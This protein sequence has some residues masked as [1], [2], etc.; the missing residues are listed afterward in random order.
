N[1]NTALYLEEWQV[2]KE[3][4]SYKILWYQPAV[5]AMKYLRK[6]LR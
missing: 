1:F 5:L 4:L 6:R 2:K 3:V